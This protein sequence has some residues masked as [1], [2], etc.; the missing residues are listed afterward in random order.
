MKKNEYG[1]I[2]KSKKGPFE[3]LDGESWNSQRIERCLWD[4]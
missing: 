3:R 1:L 2:L 4:N